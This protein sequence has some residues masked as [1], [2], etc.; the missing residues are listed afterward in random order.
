VAILGRGFPVAPHLPKAVLPAAAGT[1][2]NETGL[3]VPAVAD[4]TAPTQQAN[5]KSNT[6]LSI[7]AVAD[8]TAPTNRAN[9]KSNTALSIPAIADATATNLLKFRELTATVVPITAG[10]TAPTQTYTHTNPKVATLVDSFDTSVDK[11]VVWKDSAAA[12]V[13]DSGSGGRVKIPV[14]S[15]YPEF[16]TGLETGQAYDLTGSSVYAKVTCPTIAGT[17]REVFFKIIRQAPP[18]SFDTLEIQTS[19]TSL[20]AV[21]EETVG[22]VVNAGSTTYSPTTHAWWRFRESGG[23]IF[24]DTS[25]DGVTWTNFATTAIPNWSISAVAVHFSAGYFGAES[26]SDAYIDNVNVPGAP[27]T[28]YN[29]TGL[30]IPAVAG[31][32]VPTDSRKSR[33]LSL[34]VP[35]LADATAPTQQ[36][37]WKSNTGLTIPAVA[38]VTA[39]TESRKVRELVLVAVPGIAVVS[40]PT[41]QAKFKEIAPAFQLTVPIVAYIDHTDSQTTA[42]HYDETVKTVPIVALVS[43]PT[44]QADYHNLINVVPAIGDATVPTASLGIHQATL[45]VPAIAVVTLTSLIHRKELALTV[46]A[47]ADMTQVINKFGYHDDLVVPTAVTGV[48]MPVNRRKG[49]E[50]ERTVPIM[51]VVRVED[52]QPAAGITVLNYADALYLGSQLVDRVYCGAELVWP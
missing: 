9:W 45:V 46:P 36:V 37:D 3:V 44:N 7:P 10:V 23:T 20:Y 15:A 50:P 41:Q 43:T 35:A 17:T 34:T 6:A 38:D 18:G 25:P 24:Y 26:A 1:N 28:N 32:T 2:Y 33:E 11:T 31:V 12:V 13:W 39:P 51:A 27:I 40:A 48:T 16:Q 47:V 29:E 22:G 52:F 21:K 4:A 8:A 49:F 5:Y 30:V 19:G 42:G 14:T